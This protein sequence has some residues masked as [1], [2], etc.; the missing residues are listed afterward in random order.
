[1]ESGKAAASSS[2]V[3]PPNPKPTLAPAQVQALFQHGLELYRQGRLAEAERAHL[4]VLE[5]EP[6][7]VD[8]LQ[9]SG[10]I[11]RRTGRSARAVE[12]LTR[13]IGLND[14]IAPVHL[15]LGNALVDLGRLQEA[16]ASYDTA[17]ALRPAFVDAYVSR[18][19]TLLS[20][21]RAGDALVSF[22]EAL[23]LRPESAVAHNGRAAALIEL[24]RPVEALKSCERAQGLLP[25]APEAQINR[26]AALR[27]L[28]RHAAAL[29][30]CNI[31]IEIRRDAAQAHLIR[32]AC[33]IDLCRPGEALASFDVALSLRPE[34]AVAH[35]GRGSALQDLQRPQAALESLERAVA[36]RPDFAEAYN[37]LG[38]TLG[39]LGQHE[40]ALAS[41]GR[42][43]ALQP[44]DARPY[45][46]SAHVCLQTGRP[47]QGWSLYEWRSRID[48][49][50]AARFGSET[51]WLGDQALAGK[52][53]FLHSEQ[54][55]GDTI[56]FC[57]YGL[58]AEARGAKVVMSVQDSLRTL[59]T[60]LSPT[61]QI[62]GETQQ[63]PK[64]DFHCPLLSL[65]R[66]F[67]TT[68]DTI[69]A[70][71]RYLSAQEERVL[72]WQQALGSDGFKVGICWQ[73]RVSRVDMGRSFPLTMLHR[74]AMLPGVR[75]I[76]LQKGRGCEQL[77]ALPAG[78]R[79]QVLGEGFDAGPDAFLDSAAVLESMDL[80]ITSDTAIAHLA[81]ALGRPTWVVLKRVPDWRW[82]LDRAD[83]PWYP[84]HRLFRQQR[85]G[86]WQGVFDEI[87]R[88]L[89]R[90]APAGH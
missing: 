50:P 85:W 12:L 2:A 21:Q 74:I 39:E 64:F 14:Q 56:Q 7:H 43:I 48:G 22:D 73:G 75:L 9:L 76:S 89:S 42:A 81:G 15:N 59:L 25:N 32:G 51:M 31:A 90:L 86:D 79:V 54:G 53:L 5:A 55:L 68:A 6:G 40:A 70:A 34:D 61:I 8:A 27:A 78:M 83:S 13:A 33:L 62:I 30:A 10:L 80:V 44:G 58:L 49:E 63:A 88:E 57:R 52:T 11:A 37:N 20:L 45:L 66:A 72:R 47:E 38:I 46:N 29:E 87:Y 69:P 65:P 19:F 35:S 82:F 4:E 67:G 41:F 3:A 77:E 16:V 28:G 1:M 84:G 18:G 36:L 60:R 23:V 71:G 17:I 24:G 26:A